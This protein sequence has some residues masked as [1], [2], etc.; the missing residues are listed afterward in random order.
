MTGEDVIT[1]LKAMYFVRSPSSFQT[2]VFQDKMLDIEKRYTYDEFFS[3]LLKSSDF[4]A[5]PMVLL[6]GQYSVGKT[7]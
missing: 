2:H 5:K 1:G 4:E 7:T 6:I 3:P